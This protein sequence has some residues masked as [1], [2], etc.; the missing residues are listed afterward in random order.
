MSAGIIP[1]KQEEFD[2]QVAARDGHNP[3]KEIR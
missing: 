3:L 2:L 1:A